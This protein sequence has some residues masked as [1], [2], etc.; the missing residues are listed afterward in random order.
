MRYIANNLIKFHSFR[1]WSSFPHGSLP[2]GPIYI[3]LPLSLLR[4]FLPS[5]SCRNTLCSWMPSKRC[6]F[7]PNMV[8]QFHCVHTHYTYSHD[9]FGTLHSKSAPNSSHSSAVSHQNLQTTF[10]S[11]RYPA[12]L[13]TNR[14]LTENNRFVP[15]TYR[16]LMY[17]VSIPYRSVFKTDS[18]FGSHG[19]K[20]AAINI[21]RF[22]K[23]WPNS[24]E[25]NKLQTETLLLW[26]LCYLQ[27]Q[28]VIME[29]RIISR[30]GHTR[31]LN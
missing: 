12:N 17:I 1:F 7:I 9:G 31:P 29:V 21:G 24:N 10:P 25:I 26:W 15:T 3:N 5:P 19:A 23:T 4:D 16:N 22:Y 13:Q 8:I 11:K 28:I 27:L 6:Q 20:C 30:D 14:R 2:T 18:S